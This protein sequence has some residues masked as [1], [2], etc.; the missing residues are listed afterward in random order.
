MKELSESVTLLGLLSVPG[1]GPAAVKR[2]YEWADMKGTA[3]NDALC[4]SEARGHALRGKSGINLDTIRATAK[5]TA[6]QLEARG[7]R[8]LHYRDPIFPKSLSNRLGRHTPPLLTVLGN[9]DVLSRPSVGFCGSRKASEK[10]LAVAADC[11]EQLVAAGATIVSG[12]ATGVDMA[13]HATALRAE[14]T[15][16]IVL[17]EGILNFKIKA[18]IAMLW[19]W[20]RVAVVSEF[21]PHLPWKVHL[22]MQ[23]NKTICGLSEALVLIEAVST[24][25]SIEAGRA[26]LDLGLPLF[27]AVYEGMPDWATGNRELLEQGA[28]SLLKSRSTNRANIRHL[29][30]STSIPHSS[31]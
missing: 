15:T 24:G 22:A 28:Q 20:T 13:T 27:A 26:A 19:D 29:L 4:S 14:G 18:E 10:G 23:R 17:A 30:S 16:T 12:Y 7:V 3:L 1:I 21:G 25:G 5:E 8:L 9:I 11:A 2:F 31:H 6:S